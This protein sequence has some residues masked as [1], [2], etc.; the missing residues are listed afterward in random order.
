MIDIKQFQCFSHNVLYNTAICTHFSKITHPSQQSIGDAW[1]ILGKIGSEISTG[2]LAGSAKPLQ[3]IA[4]LLVVE[5][6]AQN[7]EHGF[8][9]LPLPTPV[10][11]GL[12][13]AMV[14][15]IIYGTPLSSVP[16]I[17]FQF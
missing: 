1:Q 6:L 2:Q 12:Y 16:F 17:Y 7:H 8:D 13:Y 4:L 5:W 3:W 14:L 15:V 9:R 11:W 10:R